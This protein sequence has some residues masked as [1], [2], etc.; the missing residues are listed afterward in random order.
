MVHAPL[1]C[2]VL[3]VL[4]FTLRRKLPQL[5]VPPA[6]CC[7]TTIALRLLLPNW[8]S[9]RL[10]PNLQLTAAT[11]ATYGEKTGAHSLLM[12]WQGRQRATHSTRG[13]GTRA[14]CQ[15]RALLKQPQLAGKPRLLLS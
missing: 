7:C 8:L 1:L 9:S 4:P 13:T 5:A 3:C 2:I 10:Q 6:T 15:D 14:N 11:A 12:R